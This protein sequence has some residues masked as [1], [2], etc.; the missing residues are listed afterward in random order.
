MDFLI[1]ETCGSDT[2][3][4]NGQVITA[5]TH[6]SPSAAAALNDYAISTTIR[7]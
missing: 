6:A 5:W 2:I 1:L 7:S 3:G 4:N